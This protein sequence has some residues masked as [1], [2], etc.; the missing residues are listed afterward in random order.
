M[1]D[2][3]RE[4]HVLAE[5]LSSYFECALP[6]ERETIIEEHLAK[7]DACT[8][9]ARRV[10]GLL[11]M[12]G[13]WSA[14]AHGVAYWRAQVAR[15]LQAAAEQPQYQTWH[16]KL[17]AWRATWG[18]RVDAAVRVVVGT[19]GRASRV[20]TEGLEELVRPSAP[21][22]FAL[23]PVPI[24]TTAPPGEPP[25]APVVAVSEGQARARLSVSG[26]AREV[27]V[28]VE[29]ICPGTTPPLVMLIAAAEGAAPRVVEPEKRPNASYFIARFEDVPPGEYLA[30]FEPQ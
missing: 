28:R 29:R 30:V 27:V 12:V 14:A 24:P 23:A 22:R 20:I 26:D 3:E 9:Q 15:A 8:E 1:S 19:Q 18:E 4:T 13:R 6:P 10:R 16:E 11:E 21:W 25:P 7:C 17:H 2:G 5:E